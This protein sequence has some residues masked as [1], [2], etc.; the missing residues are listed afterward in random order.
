MPRF[1]SNVGYCSKASSCPCGNYEA[2]LQNIPVNICLF[3]FNNRNTRKRCKICSTFANRTRN[4]QNL[5]RFVSNVGYCSKAS[6]CPCGNYEA[7]LQ[8]ISVNICLFKFNSRNTRK[9]C[10]ICSML[11]IKTPERRLN[12]HLFLVFLL[13][14]LNKQMLAG[15]QKDTRTAILTLSWYL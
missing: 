2:I 5:P 15:K 9:R 3:K 6:S 13:L 4:W 11:T 1:V 12:M 7:I 8:N 14:N 10:E